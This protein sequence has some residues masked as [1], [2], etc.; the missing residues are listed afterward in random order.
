MSE[1]EMFQNPERTPGP[2]HKDEQEIEIDKEDGPTE[3]P[4]KRNG[5]EDECSGQTS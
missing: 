2:D 5:P 3:N 4:E 1:V